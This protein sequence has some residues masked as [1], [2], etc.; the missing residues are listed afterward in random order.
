M[1]RKEQVQSKVMEISQQ[2]GHGTAT[3]ELLTKFTQ[4]WDCTERTVARYIALAKDKVYGELKNKDEI[5]NS[6]RA[7]YFMELFENNFLS[8]PSSGLPPPQIT[9]DTDTKNILSTDNQ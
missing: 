2:M 4:K 9:H 6:V 5:L 8:I 3:R 1:I 7:D